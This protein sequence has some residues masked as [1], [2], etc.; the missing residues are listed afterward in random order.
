VNRK[1]FKENIKLI[2]ENLEA[3][4]YERFIFRDKKLL[5]EHERLTVE[6]EELRAKNNKLVEK[7]NNLYIRKLVDI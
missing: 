3:A 5:N 2:N 4:D 1:Q 6:S 7:L